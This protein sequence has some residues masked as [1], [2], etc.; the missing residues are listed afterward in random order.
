MEKNSA[1]ASEEKW[2]QKQVSDGGD[3]VLGTH[4]SSKTRT[5][6]VICLQRRD[7]ATLVLP[8]TSATN[9]GLSPMTTNC[10]S[11]SPQLSVTHHARTRAPAAGPRSV[12]VA[13]ASR[14]PGVKK[15][16]PSRNTTHLLLLLPSSPL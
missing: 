12:P 16:F 8:Q 7:G 1:E 14:A 15:L 11:V 6:K 13:Q 10:L 4:G 5:L 3:L 9:M 2:E